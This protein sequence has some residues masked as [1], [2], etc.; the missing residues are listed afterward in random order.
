LADLFLADTNVYVGA[1]NDARFRERFEGFIGEQGP[2]LVSAV[3]AAEV[4]I[5]IADVARH[6]AAAGTP[7]C[8]DCAALTGR[9]GLVPPPPASSPAWAVMP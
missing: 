7:C 2:L 1:A 4:L 6:A 8:R 5:G 3:V 9:G